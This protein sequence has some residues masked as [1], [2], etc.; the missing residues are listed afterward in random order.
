[1]KLVS[2]E[3]S[4]HHSGCDMYAKC[5]HSELDHIHYVVPNQHLYVGP[6]WVWN[7]L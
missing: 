7:G 6:I 3:G 2:L 5:A 1:L 4:F